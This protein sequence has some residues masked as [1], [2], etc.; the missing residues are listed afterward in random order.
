MKHKSPHNPSD[1]F[2]KWELL[3]FIDGGGNG[4]VWKA[5]SPNGDLRALKLL[6]K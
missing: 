2:G 5:I 3:K 1:K 4:E 6:K